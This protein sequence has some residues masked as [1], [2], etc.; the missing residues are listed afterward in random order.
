[1]NLNQILLDGLETS[2]RPGDAQISHGLNLVLRLNNPAEMPLLLAGIEQKKRKIHN[3]LGELNFVHFARFLPTPDNTALQ[4]ITEFDGPLAPYVLDFA[5]EIGDVF[6][7]LLGFTQGTANIVPI[8]EHPAEFLAFVKRH[9][10]VTVPPGGPPLTFPDWPVYSAYPEQ[11]VLDITGQRDDLPIPKADRWATAVNRGDVQ[12]NILRGY[13]AERVT[14]LI[15][16]V[17]DAA[18]ARTW[19]ANKATPDEGPGGVKPAVMRN[20]GLTHGG[21]QALGIRPSWLAPFPE[22]FRQGALLRA[23]DNHDTGPNAPDHWWL[24]GPQDAPNIHVVVSVYQDVGAQAQF[25]ADVTA[26]TGSLAAGGLQLLHSHDAFHTGGTSWFGYADGIANPRI[27]TAC[28]VPGD[29]HDLQPAATAGEFVLGAAHKNI[30]GGSSLGALPAALATNGSFCAMRVLAQDTQAFNGTLAAEAARLGQTTDWLAAKLMGRW[31]EGA[32]L[33]LHPH[34]PSAN[35]VQNGRNDFD[36]APSYEYPGTLV[37]HIGERC[38]V[39]AHIRRANPRTARV[40]GARY[41]R[42]LMRRGMHYELKDGLGQRTE[43]GLFGIFICADLERQ[44]EFILRQWINGDRFAAGL[45]GTSDPVIGTRRGATDLFRI[46]MPNNAAALEVKLPQFVFTKGSLYLF[47]PG[48]AALNKLDQFAAADLNVVAPAVLPPAGNQ[49]IGIDAQFL[50]ALG[51]L[52]VQLSENDLLSIAEASVG[53]PFIKPQKPLDSLRGLRFDPRRRDFQID[54]YRVYVDCRA[55]APVQYSPLYDGWFVF[56]YAGVSQV[57]TSNLDFSAAPLGSTA[58]RGLFT[59]DVPEHTAARAVVAQAWGLASAQAPQFI[60]N[61][62]TRTLAAIAAKGPC[63][64]LVDDFARPVPRDVYFDILGGGIGVNERLELDA[65]ARTVM[66]HHDHTL[67]MIQR[68]DGLRASLELSR[69]FVLMLAEALV[70]FSRFQGSFLMHLAIAI[71]QGRIGPIVALVTL[72]NL[73]V[74]GYMSVEFLLATGIRRLLLD[75]AAGWNVLAANPARI[76]AFLQEMRRTEHAL[77][78][79]DRFV[80]R[81][82]V[83]V[84]GVPIPK[85]ESVFGVLASANRDALIYGANA[86]QFDPNRNFPQPHLALGGGAHE[87]MGRALEALITDPAITRLIA[88]KPNLRLQSMAHP[89]WFD[90]FYFR[91]FDHLPVTIL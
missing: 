86:E 80:K 38:P 3:G 87:C 47:M 14:H 9:N 4:V 58:P 90:N 24:G 30:Y 23:A 89:P 78:V 76:G 54:P 46:P 18:K 10:T 19:L 66:K 73:T 20:I 67:N 33:S 49:G 68:W 12:A 74:A 51:A 71:F 81:D 41:A 63:F 37:D 91:S 13:R 1:M 56:S 11:T 8:A 26:L 43:V 42:R 28:P 15:L 64:D 75:K 53:I 77:S 40:A 50:A 55:N 35:P 31:F 5:I 45:N 25:N 52:Q 72:V 27:A 57:L 79:V 2:V 59:L 83:V 32:P 82:N 39:G 84:D 44:F 21:M 16:R 7:M 17:L 22:A 60:H 29:Q 85:G 62:I 65:L 34:A 69:R 88:A 61:S 70:P 48:L 36:Y 6:D